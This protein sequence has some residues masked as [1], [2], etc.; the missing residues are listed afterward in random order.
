MESNGST[1]EPDDWEE[2]A[3]SAK[4]FIRWA[5]AALIDAAFLAVWVATQWIVGWILRGLP[6]DGID[7]F[8]LISIQV[9]LAIATIV[10]IVLYIYKDIRIVWIRTQRAIQREQEKSGISGRHA[11]GK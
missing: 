9:V 8:V 2:V 3:D 7:A 10:P 11:S 4:T 6:L 5:V 1:P